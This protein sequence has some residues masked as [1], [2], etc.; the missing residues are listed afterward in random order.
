M[1]LL[2]SLTGL[3]WSFELV[4]R[5][6]RRDALA[7]M[8]CNQQKAVQYVCR[9]DVVDHSALQPLFPTHYNAGCAAFRAREEVGQ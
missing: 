8:A 4:P 1:A 6:V 9:A 7:A 5:S 2:H 3:P